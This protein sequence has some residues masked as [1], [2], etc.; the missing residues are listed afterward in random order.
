MANALPAADG[1][2]SS[3]FGFDL[4]VDFVG[5]LGDQKQ[6]ATDQDQVAPGQRQTEDGHD[7]FGQTDQPGQS[8]QHD[9]AEHE[10]QRQADLPRAARARLI[11]P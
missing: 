5:R 1:A 4:G 11:Q 6:P 7:R 3:Y 8:G 9:D 10:G 2:D